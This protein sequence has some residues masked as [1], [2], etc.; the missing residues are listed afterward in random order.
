MAENK[1]FSVR[2]DGTGQNVFVS[3]VF[4][5]SVPEED[6]PKAL[7]INDD[8]RVVLTTVSGSGGGGK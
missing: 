3:D 8:G 6:R 1:K 2:T 7:S 4:L 5:L